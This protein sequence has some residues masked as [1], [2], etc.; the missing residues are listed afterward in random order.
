MRKALLAV[1]LLLVVPALPAHAADALVPPAT[2]QQ[3][4]QLLQLFNAG[5]LAY[6]PTRAPKNYVFVGFNANSDH[7]NFRLADKRTPE[8]GPSQRSL[9][10]SVDPF[11]GKRSACVKGYKQKRTVD[12]RTV[13]LRG[14]TGWRCVLTPSNHL[15]RIFGG[16]EFVTG[17]DLALTLASFERLP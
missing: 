11:K 13:Y 5:D 8:S 4:K 10:I 6:I 12:G 1:A 3:L 16:S 9:F 15:V 2:R 14:V 7:T 17:S